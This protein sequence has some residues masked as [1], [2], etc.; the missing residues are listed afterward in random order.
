MQKRDFFALLMKEPRE[1]MLGVVYMNKD[2]SCPG[3]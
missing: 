3:L 2:E 1:E